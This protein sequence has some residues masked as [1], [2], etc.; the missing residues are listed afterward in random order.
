MAASRL[1]VHLVGYCASVHAAVSRLHT[2]TN[3]NAS[4]EHL[5]IPVHDRLG[6][7]HDDDPH[8]HRLVNIGMAFAYRH[9]EM[10]T[11]AIANARLL[12]DLE[13]EVESTT[14]AVDRVDRAKLV[15][16][17]GVAGGAAVEKQGG[18]GDR[19]AVPGLWA[20]T[21]V[22]NGSVGVAG[23]TATADESFA[24]VL[25][26]GLHPGLRTP[27]QPRDP[28]LPLRASVAPV[29]ADMGPTWSSSQATQRHEIVKDTQPFLSPTPEALASVKSLLVSLS[30]RDD[31]GGAAKTL[32]FNTL[33]LFGRERAIRF[34]HRLCAG[35]EP[36]ESSC[37]E[38]IAQSFSKW[39][40]VWHAP[41]GAPCRPA[42]GTAGFLRNPS[43]AVL[44]P[45]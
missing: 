9:L 16:Y 19:Q 27:H 42:R 5:W 25:L 6:F 35:A 24:G 10:D 1:D 29:E 20:P 39:W 2:P 38:A 8:S 33:L 23:G 12:K 40:P 17:A 43:V 41:K 26:D 31:A 7:F 18:T 21:A 28:A 34:A 45:R 11:M 15:E 36:S 22:A 37:W 44:T 13:R 30:A 4:A 14:L 3:R 32:L